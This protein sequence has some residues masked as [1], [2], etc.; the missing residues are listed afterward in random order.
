MSRPR[1][2]IAAVA[3]RRT[4]LIEYRRARRPYAEFYEELG[5]GSAA[6]ARRDFNRA[7]EENL[8]EVRTTAE[9]YREEELSELDHL[10]ATAIEVMRTPHYEVTQ[11][12]KIAEDPRTGLPLLD[13]KPRLAAI[14][15]LLKIQDRRAKLLGLDSA[16]KVEVLTLGALEAEA[17]RLN[18]LLAAGDRE[19]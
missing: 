10:A 13:D 4:R 14:D 8:A 5:Y 1:A 11:A 9:A 7:L 19:A 17:A 2:D 18:E 12:G 16:Q 6:A 3:A 15:R